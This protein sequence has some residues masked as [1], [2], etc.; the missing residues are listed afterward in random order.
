M[1]KKA[2]C[3]IKLCQ[4][5]AD[6]NVRNKNCPNFQITEIFA[7]D[8]VLIKRDQA[9]TA[10]TTNL[11]WIGPYTVINVNDAIVQIQKNTVVDFIHRTQVVK[12]ISRKNDLKPTLNLPNVRKITVTESGGVNAVNE[13]PATT[14]KENPATENVRPIRN[15][16]K[17]NRLQMKEKTKSYD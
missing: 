4:A 3:A 10:K 17:P 9:V 15:R 7:G 6:A 11:P 8:Q 14:P 2:Y 16:Q 5:E 13:D 1:L 12:V